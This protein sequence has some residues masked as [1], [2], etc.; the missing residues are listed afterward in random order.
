VKTIGVSA[1]ISAL[2]LALAPPAATAAQVFKSS[3]ICASTFEGPFDAANGTG[4]AT[5]SLTRRN[6]P[7]T[8]PVEL[9]KIAFNLKGLPADTDVSCAV[10]CLG[11]GGEGLILD[12]PCGTTTA[13]G[14]LVT[15]FAN[16]PLAGVGGGCL[17]PI[18]LLA[19]GEEG[20]CAPGF[21]TAS[22]DVVI[23]D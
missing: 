1:C 10:F 6:V 7:A 18:P 16:I 13:T 20:T 21:G 9:L 17:A 15:S 23:P 12:A 4:T 8:G 5:I 19:V 14:R 11:G 2:V 22:T 3:L